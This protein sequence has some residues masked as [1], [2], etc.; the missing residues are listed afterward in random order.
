MKA[1]KK[2]L[3]NFENFI[4]VNDEVFNFSKRSTAIKWKFS[5]HFTEFKKQVKLLTFGQNRYI[6]YQFK[7]DSA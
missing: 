5:L 2:N 7:T 6:I 4:K 3:Q 1:S